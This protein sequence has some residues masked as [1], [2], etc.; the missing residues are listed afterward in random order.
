VS[1]SGHPGA[2]IQQFGSDRDFTIRAKPRE[3]QAGAA[4]V[5]G[6]DAAA[7]E[8]ERGAA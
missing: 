5:A 4:T 1:A 3:V 2:E 6:G 7:R 8:I